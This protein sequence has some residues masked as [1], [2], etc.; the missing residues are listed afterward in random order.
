MI[1]RKIQW[2][3]GFAM[4][5]LLILGTNLMD[6]RNFIRVKDSLVGIYEDRLVAKNKLFEI[7]MLTQEK[8]LAIVVSDTA[9]YANRNSKVNEKI[10]DLVDEFGDTKLTADERKLLGNFS[11]DL[12]SLQKMENG[13]LQNSEVPNL[14]QDKEAMVLQLKQLEKDL[15]RLAEI[16][17]EE[18]RRQKGIGNKAIDSIELMSKMEII[19]LVLL[20]IIIMVIVLYTPKRNRQ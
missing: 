14:E 12:N 9:F 16:Q 6:R 13:Y 17:M 19:L 11:T 18:G 1:L 5:F 7:S 20:G 10:N 3:L 2:I 15:Q 4:V 8:V